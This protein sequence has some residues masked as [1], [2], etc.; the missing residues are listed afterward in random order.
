MSATLAPEARELRRETIAALRG[1]H[2][3][4]TPQ[5]WIYYFDLG[6]SAS[7]AWTSLAIAVIS[8]PWSAAMG[9]GLLVSTFAIYRCLIFNHEITHLAT[10]AVPGLTG[11]YNLLVGYPILLPS[12]MYEGVHAGHHRTCD[13]GT[14]RDPEYVPL[15]GQPLR[16]ILFQFA[17]LSTPPLL[18]LRWLVAGPVGLA[19]PPFQRF[20]ER[21]GSSLTISPVYRRT[22]NE[23][24]HR[25]LLSAQIA[26][27]A[28]AAIV[29]GS[30][31]LGLAPVRLL[32][33]WLAMFSGAVF[34]NQ[35][36][37]LAAHRY[38]LD[39]EPT[40]RTGQLIDSIDTPGGPWTELWAPVGLRYHALHH[41]LPTLPY[42]NMGAAYRR[43]M[44]TLPMDAIYRESTSPS[45]GHSLGELWKKEIA[46]AAALVDDQGD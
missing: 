36:R 4:M 40:D 38:R 24:E 9:L 44:A 11:M 39:G 21:V 33:L 45:L 31:A 26:I 15:G 27:L 3:L 22:V 43:L 18:I 20:L 25:R 16:I 41:L 34:I 23:A 17:S 2:D 10:G 42:H 28:Y 8:V 29:L 12:I 1:L 19:V 5:P 35:L 13:Y 46:S 30:V 37:T 14:V 7:L 6:F 32:W